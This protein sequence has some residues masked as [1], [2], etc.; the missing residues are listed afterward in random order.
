MVQ[1]VWLGERKIMS[2]ALKIFSLMLFYHGSNRRQY[3]VTDIQ[4]TIN[5]QSTDLESPIGPTKNLERHYNWVVV[6]LVGCLVGCDA[7]YS[8]LIPF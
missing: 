8:R 1:L 3:T 2:I 5:F 6:R 7:G 4:Y